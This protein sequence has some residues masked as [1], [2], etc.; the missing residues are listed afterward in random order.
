MCVPACLGVRGWQRLKQ[1]MLAK[2]QMQGDDVTP[3]GWEHLSSFTWSRGV[4]VWQT[5]VSDPPPKKKTP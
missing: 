3:R 1:Q 5:I 4:M 2:T